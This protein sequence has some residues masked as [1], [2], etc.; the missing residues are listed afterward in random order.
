MLRVNKPT[1]F[2]LLPSNLHANGLTQCFRLMVS[3]F[4]LMSSFLTPF[5]WT[6]FCM[7][8]YFGGWSQWWQF[9]QKKDFIEIVTLQICFPFLPLRYSGVYINKSRIFFIVVLIWHELQRPLEAFLFRFC[10][11]FIGR[12][13]QRHYNGCTLH[14]FRGKLLLLMKVLLSQVCLPLPFLTCF[15]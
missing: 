9:R 4:W 13:Y 14:I 2:C 6:W 7:L 11:H 1:F 10:M 8:H 15:L 5:M 12:G 3:T